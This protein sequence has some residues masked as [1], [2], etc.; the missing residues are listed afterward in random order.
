MSDSTTPVQPQNEP[1]N[2]EDLK[3]AL[4][5]YKSDMFKFKERAKQAEQLAKQLQS[6]KEVI[7]REALVKKEQWK[8]LYE[9]ERVAKESA[10]KE[11]ENKSQQ[12]VDSSKINAVV[13]RLGGFKKDDY[14]KFINASN[15]EVTEQGTLDETSLSAEVDRIRQLYPELLKASPSAVLPSEAPKPQSIKPKSLSSMSKDELRDLYS[16]TKTKTK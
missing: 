10:V 15:I 16:Q 8:E 4:E 1:Q 6:E 11:L 5:D 9:K 7:E 14:A 13:Q 12:F 2:P 3:K